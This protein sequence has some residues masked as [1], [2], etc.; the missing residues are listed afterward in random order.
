MYPRYFALRRVNPYRG[1]VE[2]VDV[3]EATAHSYDGITWHLRA[4]DGQGLIRPVGVW[5]A[6]EGLKLGRVEGLQD[7]LAALETH[8]ALPFRLFDTWEHWLLDKESGLPLAILGT[9]Q[10]SEP[11]PVSREPQWHPFVEHYTGFRSASLARRDEVSGSAQAQRHRDI[12]AR[13]V[14]HAARP[15]A[16]TQWFKRDQAGVGSG[17]AGARLPAE[18]RERTLPP[19]AFPRLLVRE[20]WNSRLEQSVIAD[21]HHWL[22]PLLLLW[23]RLDTEL[24][25]QLEALACQRPRWLAKVHRLLPRVVDAPR[26]NAALVA[27]RLEQAQGLTEDNWIDN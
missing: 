1:V 25:D 9:A 19:E 6:G 5:V 23:P 3:G 14:N 27:A 24:R 22:A 13:M 18:W 15:Y 2:V 21:Y 10:A 4:D 16:M 11:R 20:T 26:L 17:E 8:P 12:L 7:L